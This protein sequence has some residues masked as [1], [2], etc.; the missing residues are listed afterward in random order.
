MT[1]EQRRERAG[2][3]AASAAAREHA[4]MAGTSQG[5]ANIAKLAKKSFAASRKSMKTSDL[6]NE[7]FLH[8]NPEIGHDYIAKHKEG[9]LNNLDIT[10]PAYQSFAK[11]H[12]P[13]L[14]NKLGRTGGWR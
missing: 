8:D 12:A 14:V 5:S 10:S 11:K 3:R 9:K 7:H 1:P 13:E 4:L 2:N 6:E